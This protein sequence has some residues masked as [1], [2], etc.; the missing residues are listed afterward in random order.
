MHS[1]FSLALG[2]YSNRKADQRIGPN[3]TQSD[4]L[5]NESMGQSEDQEGGEEEGEE[6]R[7]ISSQKMIYQPSQQEWADHQRIHIP[8]RKWCPY[9]VRGKCTSGAHRRGDKSE[10]ELEKEVPVISLDYMGPKSKDD[11]SAKID[12]LPVIVGKDR[13]AKWIFAHMVPSKG[14]D[15]HAVK[16]IRRE[17]SLAGYSRMILKSDQEPSILAVIEAVKRERAEAIE[18]LPDE[19]PVGEHQ[20]NGEVENAIRSVQSQIRTTRLGLQ[21]RYNSKIRA[22]HPI[23]PWLM[24]HAALLINLLQSRY[25]WT[26]SVREEEG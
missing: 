25:R 26:Y 23:M 16:M 4:A 15:P 13:R 2:L 10:K 24:H 5:A 9:C 21:S 6:G 11:K 8:F 20:S 12:S 19:S 14:L 22:D 18:I 1:V 7:A 17:L 3:G